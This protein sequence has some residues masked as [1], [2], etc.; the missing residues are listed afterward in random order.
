MSGLTGKEIK[1]SYKDILHMGNDNV[2]VDGQMRTIYDGEGTASALQISTD[3]V[4]ILATGVA[5]DVIHTGNLPTNADFT[6]TIA[7]T[8]EARDAAIAAKNKAGEFT[9][10]ATIAAT[11]A[12]NSKNAADEAKDA[13]IEAKNTATTQAS[14]ASASAST[15]SSHADTA[16]N[17]AA[18][19]L[20]SKNTATEQATKSKNN[21]DAAA[22]SASDAAESAA[23]IL[24]GAHFS[25]NAGVLTITVP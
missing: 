3:N 23:D 16:S 7:A 14:N 15:A 18:A 12:G 19:A 8:N 5:Y 20:A 6:G 17:E 10:T 11:S 1:Q 22:S 4:K 9:S 21:A 25:Y 2:G 13:A 24:K